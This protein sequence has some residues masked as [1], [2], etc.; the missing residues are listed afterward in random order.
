MR[1]SM[2]YDRDIALDILKR[3]LENNI[4]QSKVSFTP[5]FA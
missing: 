1:E 2:Q 5:C 4:M 3:V